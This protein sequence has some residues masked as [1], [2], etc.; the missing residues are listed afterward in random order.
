MHKITKAREDF[1]LIYSDICSMHIVI[2]A[3]TA[4]EIAA[5]KVA[6]EEKGLATS[7]HELETAITG[8]GL[9]SA[10]YQLTRIINRRRP[11]LMI[12]AGIAGSFIPDRIGDVYSIFSDR[13]G[14]LGVEEQGHFRTVFDLQLTDPNEAPFQQGLLQNHHANLLDVAGLESVAA[15]SV[16]EINTNPQRI[17]WFQQN[18]SCVV[19][20]MEGAAFHY[21]CIREKIPFLQIRSVSNDVGER[22][23]S[24]WK[25]KEAIGALNEK[26]ILLIDKLTDPD[27]T[28]IRF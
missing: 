3:A 18:T 21:V 16:N 11:D 13:L 20:S 5:T 8:V 14:D 6:L 15:T 7:S 22:D 17:S 10:T 1:E 26:L 23:K 12:Q 19:E 24:R 2:T 28:N 25:I 4:G 9:V 27:E